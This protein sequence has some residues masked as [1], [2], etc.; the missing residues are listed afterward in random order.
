[1][2]RRGQGVDTQRVSHLHSALTPGPSDKRPL[3]PRGRSAPGS[4]EDPPRPASGWTLPPDGRPHRALHCPPSVCGAAGLRKP[5]GAAR[6][7]A[8]GAE[9]ASQRPPGLRPGVAR[10]Q[11]A[12]ACPVKGGGCT[13]PPPRGLQAWRV[14]V[15]TPSHARHDPTHLLGPHLPILPPSMSFV[16]PAFP[17][18]S[19]CHEPGR[20]DGPVERGPLQGD[21]LKSHFGSVCCACRGCGLAPW[22]SPLPPVPWGHTQPRA[23]VGAERRVPPRLS[24]G[25]FRSHSHRSS[26]NGMSHVLAWTRS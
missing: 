23:V 19:G 5:D 11:L 7:A 26:G 16:V 13:K 20:C 18:D 4:P 10:S 8:R 24:C 21:Q 25:D 6:G 3:L 17:W 1:M 15:P 14:L 12:A 2:W 9:S 22:Q